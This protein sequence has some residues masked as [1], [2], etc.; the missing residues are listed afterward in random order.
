MGDISEE[1]EARFGEV[2]PDC[3]EIMPGCLCDE[4]AMWE[5]EER[6]RWEEEECGDE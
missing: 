5:E 4:Y 1:H 2:C 3:G 6:L